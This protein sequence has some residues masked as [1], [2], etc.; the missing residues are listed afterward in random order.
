MTLLFDFLQHLR[1]EKESFEIYRNGQPPQWSDEVIHQIAYDYNPRLYA[2]L[3]LVPTI[4]PSQRERILFQLLQRSRLGL[5][6]EVRSNLTAVT[7]Y[8]LALTQPDRVLKVFLALRRVRANHK[9]TTRAI[10]QYFS[11]RP[12]LVDMAKCRRPAVVDVLEHALGKNTARGFVKSLNS[13]ADKPVNCL[14]RFL[15]GD[16]ALKTVFPKLYTQEF[17]Q[18]GE[19]RYQNSYIQPSDI[20]E[21]PATV[22]ATNRGEISATLVHLYR[23]G[24]SPD[25]LS[26]VKGYV[27]DAASQLPKLRAKIGLVL[28]LSASTRGYGDRE[29]CCLSQSLALKLVLEQCCPNLKVYQ[30]GGNDDILP[31]PAGYTDLATGL[32]NTLED[33]PDVVLIV[34]DGYE[35]FIPG[36][37]AKVAATLPQIGISTPVVFCH[38]KFTNQDD[39]ELRRP[40]TNLIELS[41]W[42][43]AD[44]SDLLISLLALA[45]KTSEKDLQ[46]FLLQKLANEEGRRIEESASEKVLQEVN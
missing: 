18:M 20:Q 27:D 9:H 46:G 26:A 6:L 31:D 7:N 17:R 8:L 33:N 15:P 28:D 12:D 23:G 34:S 44:F 36:D 35:N 2:L 5:S 3:G 30:V 25:L 22:T 32:I 13:E 10:L 43:Q 40:A 19:W 11:D 16:N 42:H 14:T 24:K 4:R 29:Y 39:L 38:S 37:L 45:G 21:R 1:S 41:F